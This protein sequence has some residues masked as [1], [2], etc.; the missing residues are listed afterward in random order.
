M[1]CYQKAKHQGPQSSS[2]HIALIC[3]HQARK[4]IQTTSDIS[5]A[6]YLERALCRTIFKSPEF[7]VNIFL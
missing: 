7:R 5:N 6:A 1:L 4:Y 2:L 3:E